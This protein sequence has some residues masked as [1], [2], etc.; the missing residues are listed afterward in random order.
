VSSVT[1]MYFQDMVKLSFN[2]KYEMQSTLSSLIAN[3]IHTG[4]LQENLK[5]SD[6]IICHLRTILRQ[7]MQVI[8]YV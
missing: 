6:V 1:V 4:V 7:F 3:I 8:Y 5:Q 2:E